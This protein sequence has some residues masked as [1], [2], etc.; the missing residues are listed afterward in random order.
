MAIWY[1]MIITGIYLTSNTGAAFNDVETIANYLHAKWDVDYWDK[2]SLTFD[3]TRAWGDCN[4]IYSTIINDDDA[5]DM[6]YSTWRFFLYEVNDKHEFMGDPVDTGTVSFLESGEEGVIESSAIEEG[7]KYRFV[8]RR[9]KDHP[10]KNNQDEDGY[11]Y[12]K[13]DNIIYLENC[14]KDAVIM[15]EKN[16]NKKASKANSED[17]EN[18]EETTISQTGN[19]ETESDEETA[20]NDDSNEQQQVQENDV[21]NSEEDV[22]L[23]E[24]NENADSTL[25]DTEGE[26][27]DDS[28]QDASSEDTSEDSTDT[29]KE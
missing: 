8:V 18:D 2:S 27:N 3:G 19:G 6:K 17:E 1:S 5:E 21:T 14:E 12:M 22:G 15:N 28:T 23:S 10:G 9:P 20:E 26:Q 13:S 29:R 16:N 7:K 25:D 4:T 11:S 24:E